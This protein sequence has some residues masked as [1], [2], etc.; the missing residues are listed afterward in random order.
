MDTSSAPSPT[1]RLVI[2]GAGG[3]GRELAWLARETFGEEVELTFAVDLPEYLCP[4]VQGIRVELLRDIAR[5]GEVDYV[6]GIGDPG[7]RR[8]AVQ[9]CELLGFTPRSI[10][11][12]RVE[13]SGSVDIGAGAVVCAGSIVTTDVVLGRHVHVNVGCTISHDARLGEFATLS[14]GVHVAGNV[15]IEP[16]AFIGTGASIINGQ[17]GKPLVIGE[18]AVVAAGACVVRHVEPGALVA[19]VPAVRKR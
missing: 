8:R 6:V 12:P 1:T 18:G 10:V 17:A 15:V 5:L 19:G 16:G 11:H 9:A 2:F 4:P 13:M 14:P 7:L 3:H